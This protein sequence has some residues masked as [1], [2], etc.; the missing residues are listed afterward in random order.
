MLK[1]LLIISSFFLLTACTVGPD[2]K[3]PEQK[4]TTQEIE[5]S[6]WKIFNDPLLNKYIE[7]GVKENKNI[8]VSIANLRRARAFRQEK[9]ASFVPVINFNNLSKVSESDLSKVKLFDSGFDSSWEIDIFGGNK[10]GVETAT[11]LVGSAV[12]NYHDVL[13]SVISN[14]ARNYY[15]ARGAQQ[16]IKITQGNANLFKQT[17]K[18]I[19]TR[20]QLGEA[21]EFDFV[22]SKGEYQL[23]LSRIP[24]LEASMKSSI[25]ALS[26]LLGKPPEFLLSEMQVFKQFPKA[27]A[28]INIG[29]RADILNRRPDVRKAERELAA[30]VADIGVETANLYPK[31]FLLGDIGS[32]AR[33]FSDML[34]IGSGKYWSLGGFV[35]WSIFQGGAIRAR[36]KSK[37][38]ISDGFYASYEQAILNAL[39][40]AQTALE[41][42]QQEIETFELLQ[43]SV[44]PKK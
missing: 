7:I 38:A 14:I 18:L 25:F 15:E 31:F 32:R 27:P 12:E 29:L 6:W 4:F 1:N 11:A 10:R 30:S 42:Y 9:V 43:T 22:R 13:L 33:T 39:F 37:Q 2:Y 44:R 16:Q 28:K 24:N 40:D 23:T 35:D 17:M 5:I 36:I 21:N 20:L 3:K 19:E 41:R 8:H 26:I 34:T